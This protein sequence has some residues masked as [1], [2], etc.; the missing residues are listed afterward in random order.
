MILISMIPELIVYILVSLAALG[1][2]AVLLRFRRD[3]FSGS[4]LWLV[5]LALY[6]GLMYGVTGLPSVQYVTWDP[7]VNLIPF[8]D[9][10]DNRFF[11]LS[12]MNVLMTVPLGVLLPLVWGRYQTFRRTLSAG[13]CTSLMIEI[14]QLFCFRA[15][16]VDDLIFNTLGTCLG[17]F[18][19]KAVFGRLWKSCENSAHGYW[20]LTGLMVAL[21]FFLRQPLTDLAYRL[22]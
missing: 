17:Y 13:F 4:W 1:L 7:T 19:G 18:L 15:T 14:L 5:L 8:S 20:A 21:S 6:L 10:R 2:F 9:F 11:F 22:L 16:D 12:G 3:L